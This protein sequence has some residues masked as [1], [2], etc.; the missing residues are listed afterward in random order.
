MTYE[1]KKRPPKI[2]S[3]D[4]YRSDEKPCEGDCNKCMFGDKCNRRH[5][6]DIVAPPEPPA[7]QK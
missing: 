6:D 4:R 5:K 3:N 1:Q 2:I 7:P